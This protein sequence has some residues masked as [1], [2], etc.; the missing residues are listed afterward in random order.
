[1]ILL[2]A[3]DENERGR[4][5]AAVE[6]RYGA[7]YQVIGEAS[8]KTALACLA[9]RTAGEETAVLVAS[10]RLAGMTGVEFLGRAQALAPAARRGLL[11][12]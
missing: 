8:P 7:D 5:V 2:V 12:R 9:G 10:Q 11:L 6:R 3:V 4:L 1:L